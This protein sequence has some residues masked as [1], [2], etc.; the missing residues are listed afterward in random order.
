[1]YLCYEGVGIL[2]VQ[3][4]ISWKPRFYKSSSTWGCNFLIYC[5]EIDS[6]DS[7]TSSPDSIESH[8]QASLDHLQKRPTMS[9]T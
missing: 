6:I 4:D 1:M 5:Q 2:D 7:F 8:R 3:G 9:H